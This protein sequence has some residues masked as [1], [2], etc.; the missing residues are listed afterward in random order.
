[1]I[2]SHNVTS[3]A[4][5]EVLNNSIEPINFF[6]LV[7]DE[8]SVSSELANCSSIV[9]LDNVVAIIAQPLALLIPL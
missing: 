8:I 6:S 2:I 9:K 3:T 5:D 4:L 1:V 7:P